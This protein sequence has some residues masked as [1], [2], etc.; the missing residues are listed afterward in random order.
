MGQKNNLNDYLA[1]NDKP[2]Q[3]INKHE[4]CRANWKIDLYKN[5]HLRYLQNHWRVWRHFSHRAGIQKT[6]EQDWSS[7]NFP[8]SHEAA[9]LRMENLQVFF[10]THQRR[11]SCS[12]FKKYLLYFADDISSS[13]NL[14]ISRY[15]DYRYRTTKNRLI[16]LI[17]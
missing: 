6:S 17:H 9:N 7:T 12:T 10:F 13:F 11:R 4:I 5:I 14:L 3:S 8:R 15:L 1:K 2:K 16:T